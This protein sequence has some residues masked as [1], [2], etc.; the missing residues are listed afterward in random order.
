MMQPNPESPIDPARAPG[1]TDK[2]PAPART[3]NIPE[4]VAGGVHD[5]PGLGPGLTTART[6]PT[7]TPATPGE[8]SAQHV[9]VTGGAETASAEGLLIAAYI[10]MWAVLLGFLS[11][12][13][14]RQRALDSRIDSLEAALDRAE[15]TGSTAPSER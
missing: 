8:R 2:L 15:K 7:G 5:D 10:L 3:T 14:R 11:F 12:S 6:Q 1:P 13:W 4:G 9:P